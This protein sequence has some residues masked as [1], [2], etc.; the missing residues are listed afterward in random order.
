MIDFK[1][2]ILECKCPSGRAFIF[3]IAT[4]DFIIVYNL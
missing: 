3:E 2:D 4:N 1:N